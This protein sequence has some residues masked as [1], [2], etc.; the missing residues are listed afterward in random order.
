M[1]KT[2][3]YDYQQ[4][5]I[6]VALKYARFILRVDPGGGKSLMA[7]GVFSVLRERFKDYFCLILSPKTAVDLTWASED[8][9]VSK[10]TNFA[11]CM[12]KV[13]TDFDISC[14]SYNELPKHYDDIKKMMAENKVLLILDEAH[15]LRSED[16]NI[17]DF[18]R[19]FLPKFPRVLAL[20]ATPLMNHIEDTYFF[21]NS[22]FPG[23]FRTAGDPRGSFETFM[24]TYTVRERRETRE[25]RSY[26]DII[27]YKNLGLLHNL[28]AKTSYN[29][30]I[31]YKFDFN[32]VDVVMT[33]FE[34]DS[35]VRAVDVMLNSSTKETKFM[36]K[37][38]ELQLLTN[39]A[40]SF[41]E[42]LY[43]K[44]IALLEKL[45]EISARNEAAIVFTFFNKSY[46]RLQRVLKSTKFE[47]VY[48]MNG[49]TS[50][51]NRQKMLDKFAQGDL[52]LTT[53]VGSESLNLQ[54]ANNLIFYDLPWSLGKFIQA[55][56]R[57]G[58]VNSRHL[59]KRILVIT[60]KGTIDEYKRLLIQ[61]NLDMVDQIVGGN[62]TFRSILKQ[63]GQNAMKLLKKEL[64]WK[65]DQ[66]RALARSA[67]V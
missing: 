62:Y 7:L 14:L 44:E 19:R 28:I 55:C 31:D 39:N 48:K 53:A 15:I 59:I 60:V 43:V 3:P 30:S 6:D 5:G 21:Y 56:G 22:M 9:Q 46:R 32:F 52:L 38:P 35:Y 65:I 54:E 10:H 45:A 11:V 37:L 63:K 42:T 58:R 36:A 67:K 66:R 24:S 1:L 8:G 29:H 64:L 27:R 18:L 12:H 49:Q 13:S 17:S 33:P 40:F 2:K 61:K 47:N 57:I 16:S 25:G 34:E 26:I 23:Y 41:A 50:L 4:Q 51:Y 20:T